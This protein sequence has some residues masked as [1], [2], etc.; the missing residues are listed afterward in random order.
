MSNRI[1]AMGFGVLL[2]IVCGGLGFMIVKSAKQEAAPVATVAVKEEV[3]AVV[4]PVKPVAEVKAMVVEPKPKAK[5]VE[6]TFT[7]AKKLAIASLKKNADAEWAE[8]MRKFTDSEKDEVYRVVGG[9][10]QWRGPMENLGVSLHDKQGANLRS[11]G[12]P[13]GALYAVGAVALEDDDLNP[14]FQTVWDKFP[15][16]RSVEHL[17][18]AAG[19]V[20]Y[21]RVDFVSTLRVINN[22]KFTP[23][24][25]RG[26]GRKNVEFIFGVE[27][28]TFV[29]K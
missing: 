9:G 5:P 12:L 4:E 29:Q 13:K 14:M 27:T 18:D 19:R 25:L 16:F 2:V 15:A 21:V 7:E 6:L 22:G 23:S 24:S 17:A 28:S 1:I 8:A 3:K 20:S 11:V 26:E 10:E